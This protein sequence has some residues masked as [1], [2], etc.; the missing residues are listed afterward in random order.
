MKNAEQKEKSE[1]KASSEETPL[2]IGGMSR[3]L[4][5]LQK[6]KA[7]EKYSATLLYHAIR[8]HIGLQEQRSEGN[9]LEMKRR[10]FKGGP[11]SP[12]ASDG[13]DRAMIPHKV[14]RFDSVS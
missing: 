13:E 7:S 2:P 1:S 3:A 14:A 8:N 12:S 10:K 9:C 6:R 11:E 4:K 5:V